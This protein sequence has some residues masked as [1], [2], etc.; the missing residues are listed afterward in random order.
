MRIAYANREVSVQST[1][2]HSITRVSLFVYTMRGSRKFCQ[3]GSI[4]DKFFCLFRGARLLKPPNA[5]NYQPVS[6]TP[7]KWRFACG[8]IMSHIEC[9]L[10]SFVFFRGSGP[11]L[12]GNPI[13]LLG[14][15]FRGVRNPVPP[16][17]P[18]MYTKYR[19]K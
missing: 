4:C 1:Q 15:F 6:V 5:G 2:A 3:R 19:F 12:Q 16:L 14:F 8:L 17:V 11:V 10:S 7:L 9:L 18:R 13:N